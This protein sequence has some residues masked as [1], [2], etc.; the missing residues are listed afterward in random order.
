MIKHLLAAAL[1]L[2]PLSA[3]Q[4]QAMPVSQFL[5]KAD[6]LRKKGPLALL[7]SDYSLLKSEVNNS[8]RAL[9]AE[10]REARKAGRKP[11]TC[12]PGKISLGTDELLGSFRAIPPA[13]RGM[14]V[15]AALAA[16]VNKKYPCPA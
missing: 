1:A 7:S 5:A 6:A 15:K 9:G 2:A 10:Q 8:A 4:A 13:Q 12:M 11:T 3:V 16:F 14:P